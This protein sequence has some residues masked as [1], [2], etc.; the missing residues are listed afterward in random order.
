VTAEESSR[1]AQELANHPRIPAVD[2]QRTL[3]LRR[4][5]DSRHNRE[6]TGL[7]KLAGSAR[8]VASAFE[9]NGTGT[10]R[11]AIAMGL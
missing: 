11:R 7:V 8:E 1:G 5:C 9:S 3:W 2:G 6:R 4:D 10:L